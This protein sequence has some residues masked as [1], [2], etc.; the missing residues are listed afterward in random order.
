MSDELDTAAKV[1][2]LAGGGTVFTMFGVWLAKRF[3]RRSDEAEAQEKADLRDR[4]AKVEANQEKML[5]RMDKAL[6]AQRDALAE[7]GDMATRTDERMKVYARRVG[8]PVTSPGHKL[9]P[10]MLELI[11][12]HKEEAGE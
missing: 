12:K 6:A 10:E 5:E 8:E 3:V 4:L 7:I 11:A 2:G 9:S 1:G